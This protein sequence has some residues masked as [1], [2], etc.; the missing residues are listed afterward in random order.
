MPHALIVV[1]REAQHLLVRRCDGLLQHRTAQ[2]LG[3]PM[4]TSSR[5]VASKGAIKRAHHAAARVPFAYAAYVQTMAP[6]L[7]YSCN[8]VLQLKG[9]A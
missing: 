8:I 3:L 7:A 1:S 5:A 9:A 4:T 2:P 6:L